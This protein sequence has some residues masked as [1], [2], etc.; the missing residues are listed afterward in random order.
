MWTARG[1][2]CRDVEELTKKFRPACLCQSTAFAGHIVEYSP[3]F[4]QWN[5][6]IQL[7]PCGIARK[8]TAGVSI[9][10][11]ILIVVGELRL[12]DKLRPYP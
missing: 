11:W 4:F 7:L 2:A 3:L 5:R 10:E 6:N 8:P 12:P 1:F 9:Y